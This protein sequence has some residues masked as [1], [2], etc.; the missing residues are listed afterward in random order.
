MENAVW[1]IFGVLAFLIALG[2]VIGL[3]DSSLSER[4]LAVSRN[5]IGEF[6][7][8]CEFVCGSDLESRLTKEIEIASGSQITGDKANLCMEFEGWKK[9]YD[10]VC[11]VNDFQLN[12]NKTELLQT[13]ESHK[14]F[15]AFERGDGGVVGIECSG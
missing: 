1:V 2:I 7:Q 13:Y 12:L 8:W 11:D 3:V 6:G 4:K 14:F 10:C 9:C 15:C 5:A